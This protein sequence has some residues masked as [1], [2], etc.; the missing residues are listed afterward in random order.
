MDP[1]QVHSGDDGL[2]RCSQCGMVYDLEPG[3]APSAVRRRGA[4]LVAAVTGTPAATRDQRPDPA[5]WSVNAYAAHVADTLELLTTRVRRLL[6]EDDPDL[7]GYDQDAEARRRHFD[8]VPAQQS[9][10]L[11]TERAAALV[12]V[13]EGVAADPDAER[14]WRRT[15]THREQGPLALWQVV[16]DVVHELRHHAE[17]VVAVAHRVDDLRD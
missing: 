5:T 13:L 12:S 1:R 10:V 4:D 8:D 9:V 6:E 2:L 14:L 17:D 7:P 3:D 11:V 15:G 16:C